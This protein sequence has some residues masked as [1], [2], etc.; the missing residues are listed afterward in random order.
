MPLFEEV[1]ERRVRKLGRNHP[2]TQ[3]TVANLGENYKDAG[4]LEEAIPLLEEA[5]ESGKRLPQL[6][7][8]KAQL[9]DAYLKGKRIEE[10]Q[11]LAESE[12]QDA[13]ASLAKDSPELAAVLVSLGKD[14]LTVGDAAQ[15]E[16]LLSEGLAIC[17]QVTPDAWNTFNAQSL[18]GGAFLAQAIAETDPAKKSELL[19]KAEPLLIQGYEGMQ[20]RQSSI[21][22][23]ASTVIPDALDRLIEL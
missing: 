2:D 12:L 17:Q 14:C 23:Q 3:W 9:R 6:A 19:A 15:A 1:L 13:R 11:A 18:L 20:Q 4:R 22:P 16:R 21:P 5:Y 10:F 8:V 7:W